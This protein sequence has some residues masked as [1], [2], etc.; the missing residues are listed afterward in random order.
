MASLNGQTIASSYEQLLHTDTDGGGNGNTLVTIKDGDNGTTFGLKLAT[1]KVEVIP[2]AADDANAFEVSQNDGTAVFTVDTSTPSAT[3]TSD[4]FIAENIKHTGDTDTRI[5]M[6][7]DNVIIYAGNENQVDIGN[8]ITVFNEGGG[9]N[10]LR[11]ES[12]GNANMFYVDAGNDRIGIGTAS[13]ATKL[14]IGDG[15]AGTNLFE[16]IRLQGGSDNGKGASFGFMRGSTGTFFIGD[17]AG[18]QGGSESSSDATI[19]AMTG[20]GIRFYTNGNNERMR[21]TSGGNVGI[22]ESSPLATLHVKQ[23]DSGASVHGSADQL[24]IENSSNAGVSILS[25]TSGEGAVYFGDSGDNDI[26][27][28][29]Y[30]H[31]GNSMDFKTNTSVAMTIDSSGNVG[32][33]TDSPGTNAHIASTSSETGLIIQS[34]LGGTGSAVG[35]QLKLALGARNNSGS[36][37]AD[38]Q[39]G[40][41]LGQIMFEGQGTD[42]S[43]QGGNIKTIVTTGDGS[44]NRSNQGTAMTFETIAVGSV[45]PAE[46]LRITSDGKVGI[47][48]ANPTG[49]LEITA[50]DGQVSNGIYLSNNR[51]TNNNEFIYFRKANSTSVPSDGWT[52]G[53]IGFQVWDGDEYHTGARIDSRVEGTISNNAPKGNFIFMTADGSDPNPSERMRIT[54]DGD[55]MVG[56]TIV[57]MASGHN[58]QKGIGFD[59]SNGQTQMASTSNNETLVLGQNQG[60]NGPIL[61]FRKQSTDVGSIDVTGSSTAYNTSSDYRLKENIKEVSNGLNKVNKIKPIEFKWKSTKEKSEGFIAHELQEICEYAVTGEKDGEKMQKVDY[62]RITPILVKAIQE[63]SAKV[64]A[65]ENA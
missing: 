23:A 62:G 12:S 10:D 47:G 57:N 5:R 20:N 22:G 36:G 28:I 21:I 7:N 3:F 17:V 58:D 46:R 29:R 40:D 25:G 64:E 38:T 60:T 18:L 56:N 31:S 35:G 8:A 2:S 50:G 49:D 6:L 65:L 52:I 14:H 39:S 45:S 30:N 63:L 24:A 42:Y 16:G 54:S 9:D 37:Q 44:D 59:V 33:G 27:R 4:V 51:N 1:N 15:T 53:E 34:N 11:I 55:L 43:Y 48:T 13:P 26:G 32:I 61:T 41:I 19:Y